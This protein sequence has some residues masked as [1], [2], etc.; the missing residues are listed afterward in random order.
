MSAQILIVDDDADILKLLEMRL[1][2]SGYQVSSAHSAQQALTLFNM[3][4]PALVIS[5]LHCLKRYTA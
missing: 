1:S 4:T 2:A 3:Q 5:D